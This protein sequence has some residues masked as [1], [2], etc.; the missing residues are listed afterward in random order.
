MAI[1]FILWGEFAFAFAFAFALAFLVC[2]SERSE[3]IC[4]LPFFASATTNVG[5]QLKASFN[6]CSPALEVVRTKNGRQQ[7]RSLRSE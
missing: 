4:F 7:I 1:F 3:R 2:H 5:L 6:S